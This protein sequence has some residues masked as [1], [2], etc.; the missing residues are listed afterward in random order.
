MPTWEIIFGMNGDLEIAGIYVTGDYMLE[1]NP[2]EL[3]NPKVVW[4]DG[5]QI[6]TQGRILSIEKLGNQE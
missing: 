4:V 6:E 1:D 3:E 5:V 2:K